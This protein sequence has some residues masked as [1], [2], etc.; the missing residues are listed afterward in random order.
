MI[1]DKMD[2]RTHQ[3]LEAIKDVCEQPGIGKN[4]EFEIGQVQILNNRRV[5][6]RRT[7]YTDWP[8]PE[9]Q[10]HLVRMWIRDDGLP[11]YHG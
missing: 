8:E 9:R 3:A 5:G 6:H 2:D 1:D 11:F 4:L 7:G 10:R